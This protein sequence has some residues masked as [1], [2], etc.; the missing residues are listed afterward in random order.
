MNEQLINEQY[1]YILRLIGQKR[2]KEA[3]TQLESFLWKCPEWSLR[4]RLEQIQTSYSYMLQYMRLGVEDP[5]RRK[6]YQKL[7]TDTLEITDQARITLLD[8][9]S[10]HYYHQYRTRLSEEV[11]PLTLE[12]LMHTLESFN[13][14]LAVSGFVSDQNMEEVLKR[15]ED[16]LKTLFL[17]TWTHTNWTAEEVAAA[18]AMLQSELLPVNDLCLFTSAVT[19]SVMECFDL[20]KLLWLI[21]AYRHPN[22]QVSQRALVG[23]TFI[24]HAY[25]PRISFYPEI[26][27]RITALMEETAFERDLLRIHIQILLSQETEKIDKKMREEIIP[28]MLKSMSPMRN[29]KFGFEESDE[30]KD[31]T[32]PDWAD[33]IEK[34]GL[35]DKLREMNELQLEGADVYMSTF[36]QLKSYPFFRDISNWFYPFDKQQSDV[37]KEFRHRGKEGGS[38]LEII[39]QSGFFCNSDKYSL[40]FTMQQLPQSQRDMMLN[41]LTDQQIEELADQSKAETLKKFSERPDTVSNQY[42]HDLYRF[43]K[44][45]A[46]RLEFRDLFKES[47]CL[48]NEPDLIDILFNPEA[49]EAIANFH[50]KKKHW[51]E[52]AEA[53]DTIVDMLMDEEEAEICQK[54][55]YSLQKLKRYD[56]AIKAY[57]K[58]DIL[59]SN[60]VWTNHHL[61]T[62]Y[63]LNRQFKEALK[64]YRKVEEVLPE[65]TKV[66][67]YIGSCLAEMWNFEEALNYFFKL[68]FLESNCVKA[69]RAIGW[70]SFMIAKREQAMKYYDKVIDQ[71]PMPVDYLNAGHVAWSLGNVEKTLSLYTKAAELYG[72]K[73]LFLEV[74]RKDEEIITSKGVTPDDIPLVL[75]LI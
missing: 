10:N 73:E 65:D 66:I 69:W 31:D 61:G 12:M 48:Y 46:R 4:T 57:R 40:F 43:F 71:S 35:G 45:Y 42:L 9:V 37:I 63:R 27:L 70:C 19:L 49:M 64:Y 16:S 56:E 53:Y 8:S 72:S 26:N 22:V 47:I 15:H 32:N 54:Q 1:Q 14:D 41:Q 24:L 52:A 33:A 29:M 13:D 39:L 60:N 58:A 38:L 18:Q 23:I 21:D 34:S 17:Q 3:L 50:F 28:E 20:K 59:K 44:L 62:C 36:S 55:G 74:F 6:L 51:E 67:F 2:L 25:S 7:L 5:E 30:E 11:S 75:D 68:D